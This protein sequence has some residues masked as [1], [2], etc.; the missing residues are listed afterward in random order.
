MEKLV[1]KYTVI[2]DEK[3][4]NTV[5]GKYSW[6]SFFDYMGSYYQGLWHGLTS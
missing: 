5:G 6:S 4:L 2:D 3:L 1:T